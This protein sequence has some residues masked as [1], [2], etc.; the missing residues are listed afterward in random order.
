VLGKAG[1]LTR[2]Q[3]ILSEAQ[4]NTLRSQLPDGLSLSSYET[5]RQGFSQMTKAFRINL[6]AMSLL[7]V[8][9]GAFLVY[10]TMTF[11][12]LQRR[13]SFAIQRMVGVTGARLF[14][15]LLVE[16]LVL[17]IAGS[18]LG[19]IVGVVLGQGLLVL[20]T[21]TISDLYVQVSATALMITPWLALKG[22]GITLLAVIAATVAPALEAARVRPVIV[23]RGARD[24]QGH[25]R[26][27]GAL[28]LAGIA[29]MAISG[30]LIAGSGRS[31][32]VGFV[33]LFVFIMGYCLMIPGVLR[34]VLGG[35]QRS[36]LVRNLNLRLTLRGVRAS[37][38]RT[39]LAIV[40]LTVAVS[41]TV[42]VSIMIGSFRASVAD[43]LQDTLRSD[44]YISARSRD[45]TRAQG[46]LDPRWLQRV[47]QLSGIASVS[48]GYDTTLAI[49]GTTVPLLVLQPGQQSARGFAF[50]TGE[51]RA[52][53]RAFLEDRAVLISEPFAYH[54]RLHKGD[55][56]ALNTARAG[57]VEFKVAGVFQ[58]YSAS[59]GMLVLRR[60]LYEQLWGEHG[61]SS[62]GLMLQDDADVGG[63]WWC[64]PIARSVNIPWRSLIE[65]LPLPMYCVYW[66]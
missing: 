33:G 2:I 15:Q 20:V 50:R 22:I 3:L 11:S 52:I 26:I 35:L 61:F 44:L 28:V 7:A 54:H 19:L 48:T 62:I 42:G 29:C 14:R 31:L 59:Q 56:L 45:S 34:I 58:D 1:Q 9:V 17:G 51:H 24:E 43:W 13:Q 21:H 63:R 27:M 5:R 49:D 53:W 25:G 37:L 60:D 16:S 12:V 64:V 30:V 39:T 55:T 6:T 46:T 10:N 41:A 57:A 23:Y 38:N 18:V 47:K 32:I 66:W 4:A 8:L 36:A 65:P 40:A